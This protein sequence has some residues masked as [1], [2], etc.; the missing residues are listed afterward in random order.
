M[1]VSPALF[2]DLSPNS[3]PDLPPNLS[4]NTPP[5]AEEYILRTPSLETKCEKGPD[6]R[7]LVKMSAV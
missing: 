3:S 5:Q 4:P 7:G 6:S 2:P 1:H